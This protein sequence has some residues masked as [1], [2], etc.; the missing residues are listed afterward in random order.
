M[1][2]KAFGDH[3][4]RPR[5][6]HLLMNVHVSML[7]GT[8]AEPQKTKPMQEGIAKIRSEG[9]TPDLLV[10]RN[11]SGLDKDMLRKIAEFS[12]LETDQVTIVLL[13]LVSF[14]KYPNY[15]VC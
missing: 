13:K 3:Y 9:L 8:E 7:V 1:F 2:T 12:Q 14:Y 15:L 10:V 6:R 4:S 5:N 11:T